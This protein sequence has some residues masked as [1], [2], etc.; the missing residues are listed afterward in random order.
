MQLT[1]GVQVL[2]SV[3]ETRLALLNKLEIHTISDLLEFFPRDYLDRSKIS[4]IAELGQ[5]QMAT[6]LAWRIGDAQF[7]QFN[8]KNV[9]RMCFTDGVGQISISWFNQPYVQQVFK[10]GEKHYISGRVGWGATGLC[11]ENPDCEKVGGENLSAGRI[12]PVYKMTDGIT[13]KILRGL[14][15]QAL[16]GVNGQIDDFLPQDILQSY[17]LCHRSFA[18]ENIHFPASGEDFY[19]ARKRLVFEELF[20]LQS[21][22]LTAKGHLKQKIAPSDMFADIDISPIL[23]ALP[24]QLTG[25]QAKVVGEIMGDISSGYALNRLLQGDV[26]SGKTAVA[27]ALCYLAGKN[28]TQSAV[29]APTETLATQHFYAF[30]EIF[31]GLGLN[32]AL[33]SGSQKA[34]EKRAVK[35]GLASGEIDI[36][37]GTHALLQENVEFNRLGMVITDEQHRFGVRQRATLNAKG[38]TP[39]VL[40]MTATPIPRSLAMVLYGDMDI[41]AIRELPPGRQPIDTYSVTK[42]YH[43]RLFAFIRKEVDAGRQAYII[44]PLIQKSDE[45]EGDYKTATQIKQEIT[46]VIK[47]AEELK[48]GVF[49][50][51]SVGILHGRMKAVEKNEIMS[52]FARGEIDVLVSTT[53]VEVGINVPNATIMVI[54]NAERFGLSQLHQLRGR[55]GRG[56]HKSYCI[57]VTNSKGKVTKKRMEA[58]TSTGDGFVLSEM[59]LELRGPGEFFGTMQHGLPRLLLANLYKDMDVLAAAREAVINMGEV[60]HLPLKN[61]VD[62]LLEKVQRVAL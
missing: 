44:C 61:K 48:V 29:M 25:D 14:I 15:R 1:D 53:V 52:A 42:A 51:I 62:K 41:S 13:Q 30:T 60:S 37:I 49:A 12:V 8:N 35:E 32:C 5:G 47:F 57:L 50:D 56:K 38:A 23:S 43:Q 46:Q 45:D 24:Y 55:V 26:G 7:R 18:I 11:L 36:I 10:Q 3:G 40:V 39:H 17:D 20:L 27:M 21:A 34:K 4:P 9:T 31:S 33:L 19:K 2:K 6:I 58:M 22:L 54:E 59:D 28:G 16:D